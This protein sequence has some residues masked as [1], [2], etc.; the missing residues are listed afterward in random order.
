MTFG[1]GDS[2]EL[3]EVINERRRDRLD[4]DKLADDDAMR[5]VRKELHYASQGS[6]QLEQ[7][8]FNVLLQLD[9]FLKNPANLGGNS[10]AGERLRNIVEE[11]RKNVH[12]GQGKLAE[13]SLRRALDIIR[14]RE[15]DYALRTDRLRLEKAR[16]DVAAVVV[17]SYPIGTTGKLGAQIGAALIASGAASAAVLQ[18]SGYA[19][20]ANYGVSGLSA[21]AGVSILFTSFLFMFYRESEKRLKYDK[22]LGDIVIHEPPRTSVQKPDEPP[23]PGFVEAWLA[24]R[25]LARWEKSRPPRTTPPLPSAEKAPAADDPKT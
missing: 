18:A 7:I 14:D 4:L 13:E 8:A 10:E 20:T 24:R 1:P 6:R 21:V 22:L 15:A 16:A 11:L 3:R 25:R 17:D 2:D 19:V 5:E 12:D 9:P 23:A